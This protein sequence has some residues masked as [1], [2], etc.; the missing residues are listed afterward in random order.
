MDCIIIL[1]H[2]A[3]LD[4][5]KMLTFLVDA[6]LLER[7]VCRKKILGGTRCYTDSSDIID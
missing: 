6:P 4:D 1:L 5:D 3:F 2:A 7:N